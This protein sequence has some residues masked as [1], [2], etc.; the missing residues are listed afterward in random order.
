MG[1][2]YHRHFGLSREPFKTTPDPSFLYLGASHKEALRQLIHGINEHKGFAV[3]TG[4]I[5]TG[6]TTLIHSLLRSAPTIF[7]NIYV[8]NSG[9]RGPKIT[10]R[11]VMNT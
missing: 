3:L 8:W 9:L 10:R 11:K 4:E 1:P 2:S 6:K 5:G 7:C